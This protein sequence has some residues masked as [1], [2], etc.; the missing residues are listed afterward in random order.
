MI[1][2]ILVPDMHCEHCVS[3]IE[4]ALSEAGL[5]FKVSLEEKTV[6]IDGCEHC[7]ATAIQE[8]EDELVEVEK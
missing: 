6:L 2:K 8:L 5:N 1:K 7:V 4:T 3:R